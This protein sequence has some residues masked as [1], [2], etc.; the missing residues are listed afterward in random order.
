LRPLQSFNPTAI[1][2]LPCLIALHPTAHS[3]TAS[4]PSGGAAHHASCKIDTTAPSEI[5]IALLRGDNKHAADLAD[6]AY[7][8]DPGDRSIHK[9][10]IESLLERGKIDDAAKQSDAW[11]LAEPKEPYAIIAAGEVRFAEGD[12]LEAYALM[13]KALSADPCLADAYDGLARY[14]S[15]AGY[16][17]SA[18]KHI[19]L[20]HQLAPN[21]ESIRMNWIGSLD[22]QQYVVE[23]K[24]FLD[25][26]K[27]LDEKRRATLSSRLETQ[28][29]LMKDHCELASA[30]GP[31]RI[32]MVPM[33]GNATVGIRA[34]GLE[35]SFNGRKRTLEIDS[36]ASGFLLTRT[37]SAGMGLSKVGS[38][39]V[40]G[41]GAQG[42]STV[43]LDHAASIRIGGLEFKDCPVQALVAMGVLG[44]STDMGERLDASDGLVGPDIFDRYAVTL[45][46]VKHEVRLD[47]LPQPPGAPQ[48]PL[49]ALGGPVDDDWS[50]FER[51]KAT[52]MQNWTNVYRRGHELILPTRINDKHPA[53]FIVDTGSFTNLI[54]IKTAK[55]VTQ[56][57]DSMYGVRGVSGT[58]KLSE[59]GKFTLDFAGLR[60]PVSSMDALDL[61][62]FEGVHGFL[63]YSSLQQL[64]MHIDYRDNLM[65]F[66]APAARK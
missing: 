53:L 19:T 60:L 24:K 55:E 34:Y 32:P 30:S 58:E 28:Q 11:A 16:R 48:A 10:E 54:D 56:A 14:E 65:L 33:Y 4:P 15:L 44:G 23:M 62:R 8:K 2:I 27:S 17:A 46:Y 25:E 38:S 9:L 13:L 6:A 20:A 7:K 1:L 22:P 57:T 18:F 42:S 3:Q 45:D 52:S 31:A 41:F 37:A 49:D 21:D 61:S 50:H 35:I 29:S 12:W 5:Q 40:G 59:A 26:T 47:P 39:R 66:E 63:G 51:C 36:G 43:D 64:V